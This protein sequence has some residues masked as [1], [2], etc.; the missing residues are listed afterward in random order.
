MQLASHLLPNRVVCDESPLID[1]HVVLGVIPE[2]IEDDPWYEW[3]LV[4]RH[5][6]APKRGSSFLRV[7]LALSA[8]GRSRH[9][10]EQAIDHRHDSQ[11]KHGSDREA[12]GT[13]EF[14]I[15]GGLCGE[16]RLA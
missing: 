1:V 14:R 8:F 9:A 2:F 12:E 5:D 13:I 3:D 6:W 11:C 16:W 4:S 15:A 7:G 10:E